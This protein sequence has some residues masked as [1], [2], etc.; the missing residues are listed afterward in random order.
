MRLTR[1]P[2]CVCPGHVSVFTGQLE[3]YVRG[4][5]T[6]IYD[7]LFCTTIICLCCYVE[8]VRGFHPEKYGGKALRKPSRKR[9]RKKR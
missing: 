5:P 2:S 1:C 4:K 3:F 6:A 7:C 9:S 8:H